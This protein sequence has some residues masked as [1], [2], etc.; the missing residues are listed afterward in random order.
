MSTEDHE[1]VTEERAL[2]YALTAAGSLPVIG[3]LVHGGAAGA[4]IT[5][6]LAMIVAGIIALRRG[7]RVGI[8]RAT[9]R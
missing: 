4:G 3:W 8:P 6:S 1:A 5:L 2:G 7:R 9:L